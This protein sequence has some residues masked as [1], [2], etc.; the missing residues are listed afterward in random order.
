MSKRCSRA[1][2]RAGMRK[3]PAGSSQRLLP[4]RCRW[5]GAHRVTAKSAAFLRALLSWG[6]DALMRWG[7]GNYR[8]GIAR[9]HGFRQQG[10]TVTFHVS[11][12]DRQSSRLNIRHSIFPIRHSTCTIQHS[13]F[14][15]RHSPFAIQHSPFAIRHSSLV[16]PFDG[17]ADLEEQ[18]LVEVA[19]DDLH[20]D[21]EMRLVRVRPDRD[22]QRG[23]AGQAGRH[24]KHV[25]EVH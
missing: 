1:G 2:A 19:A 17:A 7:V 21:R 13:P 5:Y 4:P 16:H 3:D 11:Q 23:D 14:T 25:A 15:I 10:S 8:L 22:V 12:F 6:V 9:A 20:T 18:G 24:R